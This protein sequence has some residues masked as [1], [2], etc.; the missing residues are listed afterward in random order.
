MLVTDHINIGSFCETSRLGCERWPRDGFINPSVC[1]DRCHPA[2]PHTRREF[3]PR[4]LASSP[5]ALK[6]NPSEKATWIPVRLCCTIYFAIIDNSNGSFELVALKLR[7]RR[8][9]AG[10]LATLASGGNGR[11]RPSRHVRV[12]GLPDA[13]EF[14]RFD[15]AVAR[16]LQQLLDTGKDGGFGRREG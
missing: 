11:A 7:H 3:T 6:I 8:H 14:F 5:Q 10:R 16:L 4:I 12:R 9:P 15:V 1:A 13:F 2:P